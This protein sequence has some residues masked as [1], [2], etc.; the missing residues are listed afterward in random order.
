MA[1]LTLKAN[2]WYREWSKPA[3][4]RLSGPPLYWRW[5]QH[6]HKLELQ[7][8]DHLKKNSGLQLDQVKRHFHVH[9]CCGTS[10]LKS[11]FFLPCHILFV[12][13]LNWSMDISLTFGA[14]WCRIVSKRL[15]C[16]NTWFSFISF[17]ME[18]E[19]LPNAKTFLH[20]LSST[21]GGEGMLAR[22]PWSQKQKENCI[23]VLW[24]LFVYCWWMATSRLQAKELHAFLRGPGWAAWAT[25]PQSP[26]W[27]KIS[28]GKR[29]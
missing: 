7:V 26:G 1:E 25:F 27:F 6:P 17:T 5:S 22:F 29:L 23:L 11:E 8:G 13:L 18:G 3:G 20:S 24:L 2:H 14:Q 19:L 4:F 10:L 12:S 21:M 9:M 16:L 15:T 28:L